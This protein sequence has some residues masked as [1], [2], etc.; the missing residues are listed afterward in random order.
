MT[1]F[2]LPLGDGWDITAAARNVEIDTATSADGEKTT[3]VKEDQR[4][5]MGVLPEYGE[6]VITTATTGG[7]YLIV[8]SGLNSDPSGSSFQ[9]L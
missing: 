5:G 4:C 9:G 3:M 8:M 7:R 1:S 6:G 2:G